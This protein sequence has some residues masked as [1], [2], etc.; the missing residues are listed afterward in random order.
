[1][2]QS[3]I[4]VKPD[5]VERGLV[6]EIISRFEKAGLTIAGMKM[7]WIDK[8]HA[9]KHYSAHVGK[10]FYPPV[11]N[12]VTSGPIVVAVL[13][14]PGAVAVVRKMVGSTE[15]HS[16]LPGTIRG[17]FAHM[18]YSHADGE[19]SHLGLRNVIH[20]SGNLEEAKEEIKL[21]FKDNELHSYSLVHH[22]HTRK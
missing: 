14:G 15:P 5:G 12:Y 9:K 18:T 3:L 2:E 4:F 13:E 21:W 16:A 6:G 20:A 22:K 10:S 11:E 1:M 19:A 8:D 7:V 17:D